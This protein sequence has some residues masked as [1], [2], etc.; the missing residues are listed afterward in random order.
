MKN[1]DTSIR[2]GSTNF[3]LIQISL[4]WLKSTGFFRIFVPF[5]IELKWVRK[6]IK[7]KSTNL[8]HFFTRDDYQG[9]WK[10]IYLNWSVAYRTV[11]FHPVSSSKLISITENLVLSA[12]LAFLWIWAWHCEANLCVYWTINCVSLRRGASSLRLT[13]IFLR[14]YFTEMHGTQLI[15]ERK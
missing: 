7:I 14:V 1:R 13:F 4:E 10:L 8:G 5:P 12:Y 15:K 9:N 6:I 11:S 3:K 2:S